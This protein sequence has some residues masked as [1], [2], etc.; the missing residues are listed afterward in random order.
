MWL[1]SDGVPF[2]AGIY[3][4]VAVTPGVDFGKNAEGCLRFSYANSLE[5]IAR[6]MERIGEH[7]RG[8]IGA[9]R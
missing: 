9:P 8:S 5:E 7:L 3:Q 1:L 6:A 4:Q 2:T